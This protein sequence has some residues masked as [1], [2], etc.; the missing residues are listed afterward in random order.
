MPILPV[1][2]A[3]VFRYTIREKP[4]RLHQ[5]L[6]GRGLKRV[7]FNG[8]ASDSHTSSRTPVVLFPQE[9]ELVTRDSREA[10][11][12]VTIAVLVGGSIYQSLLKVELPQVPAT[13]RLKRGDG[14]VHLIGKEYVG[15]GKESSVNG[16]TYVMHTSSPLGS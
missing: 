16:L 10:D 14:P 15:K 5:P 11:V 1:L 4:L 8:Y 9:I 3:A 2:R 6:A 13:L 12:T 7:K